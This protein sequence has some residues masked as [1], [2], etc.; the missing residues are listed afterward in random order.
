MQWPSRVEEFLQDIAG[1]NVI[2]TNS[3]S[4]GLIENL[5]YSD[6]FVIAFV[7]SSSDPSNYEFEGSMLHFAQITKV[8]QNDIFYWSWGKINRASMK[9]F[10]GIHEIIIVSKN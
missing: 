10:D 8:T 1:Y 3:L 4:K 6:F 2:N 7:D 5:D 9:S